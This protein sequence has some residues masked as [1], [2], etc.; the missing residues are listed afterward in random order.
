MNFFRTLAV[1]VRLDWH[2]QNEMAQYDGQS[3]SQKKT[4]KYLSDPDN[5]V[6][7][8]DDLVLLGSKKNTLETSGEDRKSPLVLGGEDYKTPLVSSVFSLRFSRTT[9]PPAP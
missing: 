8:E 2:G 5:F 7:V 1:A 3:S 6:K 9:R 4:A